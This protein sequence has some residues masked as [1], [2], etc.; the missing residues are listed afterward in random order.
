MSY[1]VLTD[2]QCRFRERTTGSIELHDRSG[3]VMAVIPAPTKEQ[4]LARIDGARGKEEPRYP[5]EDVHAR[6]LRL[7]EIAETE[8]LH[9]ARVRD[10]LRRMRAGEKVGV[11]TRSS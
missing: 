1:I 7:Q 4:I 2:E 9:A 8:S 5:A 6:L 3:R 11:A 10:L